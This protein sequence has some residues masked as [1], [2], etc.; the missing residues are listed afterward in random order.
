MFTRFWG[1][2]GSRR[3]RIYPNSKNGYSRD[4]NTGA[5]LTDWPERKLGFAGSNADPLF[6]SPAMVDSV[7]LSRHGLGD[8]E[9]DDVAGDLFELLSSKLGSTRYA[10]LP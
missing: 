7:Y 6:T 2:G 1:T 10:Q 8:W 3:S 4:G 9:L 5:V